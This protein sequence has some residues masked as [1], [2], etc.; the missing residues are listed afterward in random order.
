M[1]MFFRQKK[2]YNG[3]KCKYAHSKIELREAPNLQKTKMCS[4]FNTGKCKWGENCNFAHGES[5]LIITRDSNIQI[6]EIEATFDFLIKSF[7]N[8]KY[9]I[10]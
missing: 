7:P 4:N 8:S 5:E 1:C 3:D 6:K 2:C 9:L 10:E